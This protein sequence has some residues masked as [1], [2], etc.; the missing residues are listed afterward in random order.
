LYTGL[1][2]TARQR[3]PTGNLSFMSH[4]QAID[5]ALFKK[6][7]GQWASG[8]TIV[9][10]DHDGAPRGMTASSFTSLSLNPPLVMFAVAQTAHFH[11]IISGA[12]RFGVNI[13]AKDQDAYSNHFA[14]RP[15]EGLKITWIDAEGIPFLDGSLAHIA[16]Q[17]EEAFPGGDHTIFVG[18]I[19][20]SQV[21]PERSPLLFH[22]GKYKILAGTSCS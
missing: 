6:T 1:E 15:D 17:F 3:Q 7:L 13:L 19:T 22:T 14:G 20:H 21:W 16:C 11:S 12:K 8:V 9:T 10:V 4:L 2:T 18:R 5:S